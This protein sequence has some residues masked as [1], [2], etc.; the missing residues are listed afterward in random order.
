[1]H[2]Y[3]SCKSNTT[4]ITITVTINSEQISFCKWYCIRRL[5][6][7]KS[8]RAF[9]SFN[10]FRTG[11]ELMTVTLFQDHDKS[12]FVKVKKEPLSLL[13]HGFDKSKNVSLYFN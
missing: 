9:C 11:S 6:T 3:V 8:K 5:H 13:F 7:G 2:I 12:C 10:T 1:M 4:S